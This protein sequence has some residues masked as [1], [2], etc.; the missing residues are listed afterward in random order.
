MPVLSF[1][2]TP[3]RFILP[4]TQDKAEQGW[5]EMTTY[6]LCGDDYAV[7]YS[8]IYNLVEG[9]P[10]PSLNAEILARRIRSWNYTDKTGAPLAITGEAIGHLPLADIGFLI[11]R[12]EDEPT[13]ELDETLKDDSSAISSTPPTETPQV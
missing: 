3:K 8:K 2:D 7:Y 9:A 13:E 10:R 5:V 6:P 4:S 11:N 12:I 1:D